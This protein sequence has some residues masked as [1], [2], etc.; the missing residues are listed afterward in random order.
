[1]DWRRHLEILVGVFVG[2]NAALYLFVLA[3][4]PYGNLPSTVFA[5]HIIMDDNQRFQYPSIVR[6]GRFDSI[7]IGTSTSRLLAPAALERQFGGHFA[8]LA[9]NSATAWEQAQIAG[10]FLRHAPAPRTLIV[11]LDYV[12]CTADADRE[13]ITFRGFPEWMYDDDP[14]N[15]LI[16]LYNTR[17]IEIAGRRLAAALLGK[18]RRLPDDG[19]E[20]FTPPESRYDLARARSH[21]YGAGPRR[22]P[23]PKVPAADA[24]PAE[25]NRWQFPAIDWLESLVEGSRWQRAVLLWPPVHVAAQP[26]PGSLEALRET[27]CKGRI[28]ALAA[29]HGA[30]VVDFRLWSTITT[31]DENYWDR[32]HY[33]LSIAERVES[34]L[35]MALVT[36]GD[37]PRG[38]WQVKLP[39]RWRQE[40]AAGK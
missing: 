34:G 19:Y 18:R 15:D 11:G 1:M 24:T 4:N 6:S 23:Q 38:D 9:M 8:N 5:E 27:E 13:R 22:L 25:R 2:L 14:W 26:I 30:A 36:G 3:M 35:A 40:T 17:S 39:P 7:V 32:L 28:A 29:R 16:H 33:R 37:D 21:I 12:W 20:V 10:L 31:E